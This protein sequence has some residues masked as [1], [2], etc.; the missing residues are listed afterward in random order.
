[1]SEDELKDVYGV[2]E[3]KG[4]YNDKKGT[5]HH[6]KRDMFGNVICSFFTDNLTPV[7]LSRRTKGLK[8][9][10]DEVKFN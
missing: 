1:M 5:S 10:H 9:K 7:G 3:V 8:V 6:F 2:L 4:T